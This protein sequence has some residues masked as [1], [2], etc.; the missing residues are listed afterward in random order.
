M[1]LSYS[2]YPEYANAILARD[3]IFGIMFLVALITFANVALYSRYQPRI[4]Y[5]ARLLSV[6]G[7][8][9]SMALAYLII[10]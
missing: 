9:A 7:F 10:R 2:L 4:L 3:A 6:G 5:V 8:Y 1:P